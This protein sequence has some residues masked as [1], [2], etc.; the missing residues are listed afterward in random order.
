VATLTEHLSHAGVE[1]VCQNKVHALESIIAILSLDYKKELL[2]SLWGLEIE[3]HV[4][5]ILGN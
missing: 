2:E 5:K 4:E 3:I 1:I